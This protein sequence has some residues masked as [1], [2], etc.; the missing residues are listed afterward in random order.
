MDDEEIHYVPRDVASKKY[1]LTDRVAMENHS[2]HV[3]GYVRDHGQDQISPKVPVAQPKERI[4]RDESIHE[5]SGHWLVNRHECLYDLNGYIQVEAS[6]GQLPVLKC[7]DEEQA[8][9]QE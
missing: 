6:L 1:S 9:R 3:E 7:A 8:A 4:G 5:L 2:I